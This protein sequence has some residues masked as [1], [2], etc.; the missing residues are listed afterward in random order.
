MLRQF[1]QPS[2]T[3]AVSWLALIAVLG[4]T[5]FAAT[6][7]LVNIGDSSGKY[8]ASVNSRGALSTAAVPMPPLRPLNG[9]QAISAG[10]QNVVI[11]P[12][13]G[14]AV[15]TSVT[16]ENDYGQTNGAPASVALEL[17]QMAPESCVGGTVAIIGI[18]D[19][20]AGQS[21]AQTFPSGLVMKPA[22]AGQLWCL[23]AYATVKGNPSSYTLPNLYFNGYVARGSVTAT[24][25]VMMG[26]Q[27]VLHQR[28]R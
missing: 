17:W 9:F 5:A 1:K 6:A 8:I 24:Q 28:N 23:T 27:M 10:Q 16:I 4:G 18:Y 3:T 7:T 19:V 20:A 12:T 11:P 2:L 21:F 22:A 26:N 25:T 14:S 15:L 13:G